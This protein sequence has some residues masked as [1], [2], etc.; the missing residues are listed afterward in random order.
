MGKNEKARGRRDV[1]HRK[2]KSGR[3][4]ITAD[5]WANV[6]TT[7]KNRTNKNVALL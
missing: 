4:G 1:Q 6:E 5:Y 2:G 3:A 7:T